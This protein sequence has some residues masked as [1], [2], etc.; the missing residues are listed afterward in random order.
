MGG[1]YE[2]R[3]DYMKEIRMQGLHEGK[4]AGLLK[5]RR[6]EERMDGGTIYKEGRTI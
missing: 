5:G 1:A 4:K 3:K 6:M 2:G